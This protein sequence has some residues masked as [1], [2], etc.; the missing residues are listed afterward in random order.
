MSRFDPKRQVVAQTMVWQRNEEGG[1]NRFIIREQL[2]RS[3]VV[4]TLIQVTPDVPICMACLSTNVKVLE[5][6]QY[7]DGE[8]QCNECGVRYGFIL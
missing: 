3:P 7:V 6:T 4:S 1:W 8:L 2:N 5:S